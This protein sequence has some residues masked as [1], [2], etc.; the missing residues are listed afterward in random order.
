MRQHL[1]NALFVRFFKLFE[2]PN[3]ESAQQNQ[4]N[5]LLVSRVPV[6]IADIPRSWALSR[7]AGRDTVEVNCE[8]EYGPI[9]W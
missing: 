2:E 1:L 4:S 8:L 7:H 6:T 5:S 3:K 9:G